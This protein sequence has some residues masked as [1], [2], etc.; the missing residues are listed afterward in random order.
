MATWV[1]E[2]KDFDGVESGGAPVAARRRAAFTKAVV[3]A[4]TSLAVKTPWRSAVTC[5]AR[6]ER[7][8]CGGWIKVSFDAKREHAVWRCTACRDRGTI[9][10][11]AGGEHDLSLYRPRGKRGVWGFG[12]EEHN[13]L[14]EAFE[15]IPEARAVIARAKPEDELDEFMLVS[16]TVPE[17][18]FIYTLVEHLTDA[19]GSRQRHA[20]LDGLRASLSSSIDGF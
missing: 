6:I 7:K 4:A 18:D 12:E 20:L 1:T 11:F 9:T 14:V 17:L 16:A 3:E 8:T 19:T 13:V 2:L 15:H 10:G 5:I